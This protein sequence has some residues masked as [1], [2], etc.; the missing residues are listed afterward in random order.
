MNT[1]LEQVNIIF[2]EVLENATLEIDLETSAQ[3]IDNWDS[4]NHVI[5][6]AAIESQFNISFELDEMINFK[7]VGDILSAIKSKIG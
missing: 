4:L 3:N 1:L 5:L 2:R 6:I 7:N